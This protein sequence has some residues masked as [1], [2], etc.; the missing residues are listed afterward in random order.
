MPIV[1]DPNKQVTDPTL[2]TALAKQ[3]I[4][5][6]YVEL[7][8]DYAPAYDIQ[9]TRI[10]GRSPYAKFYRHTETNKQWMV[11][12]QLPMVNAD[13]VKVEVGWQKSGAKYVS[14][15]NQFQAQVSDKTTAITCINDQPTGQK[16][17]NS[18]TYTP[19]LYLDG[20]EVSCG[21]ETLP[22]V[23]PINAN[24]QNNVLEWDYGICKR[25]LRLI[26]GKI[27]GTWVFAQN[28]NGEVRIQYDQV[29]DFKLHLGQYAISNTEELIPAKAFENPIFGY[30]FTISDSATFYPDAHTESTSVDGYTYR[31]VAAGEAWATLKAGDGTHSDDS[32]TG[33][34]TTSIVA[35]QS[36]TTSNLWTYIV[37][38]IF[39]FDT[40]T[41][42]DSA[43]ISAATLSLY[44]KG[45]S[46]QATF[47][48]DINIYSSLPASNT[49]L[50]PADYGTLGTTA[51]STTKT[52]ANW[53]ITG[54]NDFVL[55]AAGIAA[56]PVSPANACAKFGTRSP[57]LDVVGT[58]TWGPPGD[59]SSLC[60]YFSEQGNGYKP[61]LVVTYSVDQPFRNYY[62]HI[63]AH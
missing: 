16:K 27:L 22:A 17:G 8:Q 48:P 31:Y 25:R 10:K 57:S 43:I 46:Q 52:Y 55:N 60:G 3:G 45:K 9:G 29:G 41:L 4:D 33:G 47:P 44:G 6:R 12:S 56:I 30:P 18:L 42:P 35:L 34:S 13:G 53:S 15:V 61:K 24:Y 19:H 50:V 26:E 54:Y 23:D 62:P 39:L 38:D 7:Y 21:K 63:L 58:P 14:K 51:F 32:A 28:P 1:I 49:A 59:A 40:S 11:V 20:V 2:L 37:R 36:H 5:Y